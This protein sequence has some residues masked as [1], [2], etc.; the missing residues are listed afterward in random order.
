MAEIQWLS[1]LLF[2]CVEERRSLLAAP[3]TLPLTIP[4]ADWVMCPSPSSHWQ[5]ELDCLDQSWFT[6]IV[7]GTQLFHSFS[8]LPGPFDSLLSLHHAVTME[9]PLFL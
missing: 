2:L 1:S 8:K 3:S 7:L 4:L 6:L 5:R 9:L